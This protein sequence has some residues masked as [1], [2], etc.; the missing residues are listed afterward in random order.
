MI[1]IAQGGSRRNVT[2]V[3][4]SQGQKMRSAIKANIPDCSIDKDKNQGGTGQRKATNI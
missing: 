3:E 1:M 2:S 4:H